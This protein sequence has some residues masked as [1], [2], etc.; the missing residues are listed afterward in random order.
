MSIRKSSFF[1]KT[2]VLATFERFHLTIAMNFST[3]ILLNEVRRI[4]LHPTAFITEETTYLA[5][6]SSMPLEQNHISETKD[7]FAKKKEKITDLCLSH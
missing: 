5:V 7:I 3:E 4:P 6:L 2:P 1:T